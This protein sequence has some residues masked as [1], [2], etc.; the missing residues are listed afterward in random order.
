MGLE[1][2]VVIAVKYE[3]YPYES[4]YVDNLT[5]KMLHLG[6]I[7]ARLKFKGIDGNLTIMVDSVA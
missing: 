5:N 1:T 3:H 6:S 4:Y 7:I 2:P